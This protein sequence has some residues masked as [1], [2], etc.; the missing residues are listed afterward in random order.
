MTKLNRTIFLVLI[1]GSIVFS[2]CSGSGKTGGS[3][4]GCGC[5]V[6]KGFVGY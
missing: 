3:R 5:G 4:K 6:H 1:I 2:A